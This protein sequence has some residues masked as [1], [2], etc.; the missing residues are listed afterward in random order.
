MA[1]KIAIVALLVFALLIIDD[2]AESDCDDP[3]HKRIN[4][5]IVNYWFNIEAGKTKGDC[6]G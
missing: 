6:G 1:K 2:I 4:V 3:Y 5:P